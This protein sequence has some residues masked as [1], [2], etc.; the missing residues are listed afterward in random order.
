MAKRTAWIVGGFVLL[1]LGFFAIAR[2]G[3]AT[4]DPELERLAGSLKKELAAAKADGIPVELA[5]F[6]PKPGSDPKSGKAKFDAASRG[7]Q[8]LTMQM[9]SSPHTVRLVA[10]AYAGDKAA[11]DSLTTVADAPYF[12]APMVGYGL[13]GALPGRSG[14]DAQ[15]LALALGHLAL[16]RMQRGTPE[17]AVRYFRAAEMLCSSLEADYFLS[18]FWNAWVAR[19]HIN[20]LM[21]KAAYGFVSGDKAIDALAKAHDES[22]VDRPLEKSVAAIFAERFNEWRTKHQQQVEAVRLG[23]NAP[24]NGVDLKIAG[25]KLYVDAN[26][27]VALGVLREIVAAMRA[28]DNRF[29]Q[30][31]AADK[32]MNS[33]RGKTG[34]YDMA[35]AKILENV[36]MGALAAVWEFMHSGE[37]LCLEIA[38]DFHRSHAMPKD[39]KKYG[40]LGI[41]PSTGRPY[42]YKKFKSSFV[43]GMSDVDPGVLVEGYE[44]Y[45]FNDDKRFNG[46]WGLAFVT[47]SVDKDAVVN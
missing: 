29:E 8:M 15:N 32:V 26:R 42:L 10:N 33:A 23:D 34:P 43:I 27:A 20:L 24:I 21:L 14:G 16:Y 19:N 2:F 46:D 31:R 28:T 36:E 37:L 25:S 4:G 1:M 44:P 11:I 3:V 47:V 12:G 39:L 22:F 30:A 17:E 41:D 45:S 5:E 40:A 18:S 35:V 6:Y 9:I 13:E 7:L 38:K